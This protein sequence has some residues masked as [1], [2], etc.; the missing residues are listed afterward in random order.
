ML[1]S[2]T[3]A[4]EHAAKRL[5]NNSSSLDKGNHDRD[6]VWIYDLNWHR[7]LRFYFFVFSLVLVYIEKIHQTLEKVFDHIFKHLKVR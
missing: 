1:L 4:W 6:G 7:F 3:T 2:I 5:V